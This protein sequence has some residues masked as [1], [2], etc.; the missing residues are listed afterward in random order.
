MLG[1]GYLYY[2]HHRVSFVYYPLFGIGIPSG[3]SIH[4]IDISKYQ[5]IID[6]KQVKTIA[7]DSVHIWFAFIKAT[8]GISRQDDRFRQNW[9]EARDAGLIRGA[10]HFFYSTRDPVR[11]AENFEN[12]VDLRTG[13]LPPV[14][15]I[16]VS[17]DQ[18]DSIIRKSALAW[19][20]E[21]QAHYGVKPIIY[22]NIRFYK[23]HLGDQFNS[24]PLWLSH[25]Y[26]NWFPSTG[27][28]WDFWQH[29]DSGHVD[30]IQGLV[31]FNVFNGDSLSLHNLCVP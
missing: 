5:G 31:D 28:P 20:N 29:S 13:D 16:E 6:W 11:Q 25:F 21:I 9:K 24:Y 30:G 26:Q 1:A 19:L 10:Y 7:V 17:N 3:Y 2:I 23:R 27:R 15:D 18:P 22:T 14:L 4:G 12:E 8:E